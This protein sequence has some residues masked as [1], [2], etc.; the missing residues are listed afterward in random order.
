MV[1]ILEVGSG[2]DDGK[3]SRSFLAGTVAEDTKKYP[4]IAEAI[5]TSILKPI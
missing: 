5:G 3:F 4:V 1:F 2:C